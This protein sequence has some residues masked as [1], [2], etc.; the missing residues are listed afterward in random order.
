MAQLDVLKGLLGNP[1]VDDSVLQ[2]CLDSGSDIICDLRN[3]DAVETKYLTTQIKIAIEIF[4]KMGAEG[5][6]EHSENGIVR[7]YEKG[8]ISPSLLAQ[9]TPIVKTPYSETRTVV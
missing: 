9:I 1:P 2:Y 8:D 3:S 4:N 7:K 6:V 5:Q